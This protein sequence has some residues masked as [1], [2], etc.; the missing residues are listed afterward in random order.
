MRGFPVDEYFGEVSDL[1]KM[2]DQ[3]Y[4]DNLKMEIDH[5][6]KLYRHQLIRTKQLETKVKNGK[7]Y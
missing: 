3:V 6:K 4:V 2:Y 1:P 5:Y 7:R